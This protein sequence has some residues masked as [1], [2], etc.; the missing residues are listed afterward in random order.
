MNKNQVV[1]DI[2]VADKPIRQFA[3]NGKIYVEARIGQEY[4]IR[5]K[6]NSSTRILAIPAVDGVNALSGKEA[7]KK[8]AGYVIAGLSSYSVPGF[9]TSN[10][11][12]NAFEFARK[13][14]SYAAKNEDNPNGTKNCGVIGISLFAEKAY[15]ASNNAPWKWAE[16]IDGWPPQNPAPKPYKP[17]FPSYPDWPPKPNYD[18]YRGVDYPYLTCQLEADY[19][20][21]PIKCMSLSV[22]H[23]DAGTA[24]SQKE[25]VDKVTDTEFE[26]GEDLGVIEIFYATREALETMGINLMK[27]PE[28]SFPTSFPKEFCKPPKK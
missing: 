27:D 20:G 10:D 12:A 14:E 8:G 1:I 22:S 9:R 15:C 7:D 5:I 11:K 19:S 18:T 25:I 16:P 2:L 3:H 6:N 21:E 13:E 4:K 17:H 26:R 23:F 28:V 24:F